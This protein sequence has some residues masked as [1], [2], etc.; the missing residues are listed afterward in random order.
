[1]NA[2]LS[3]SSG[4]PISWCLRFSQVNSGL[5][6]LQGPKSMQESFWKHWSRTAEN[7]SIHT[8][9]V[10][11][12]FFF[13]FFFCLNPFFRAPLK[14]KSLSD[15]CFGREKEW[16][17]CCLAVRCYCC[18]F[19]HEPVSDVVVEAIAGLRRS[20][21]SLKGTGRGETNQ[22]RSGTEYSIKAD[23]SKEIA[24]EI[25]TAD[26]LASPRWQLNHSCAETVQHSAFVQ[27]WRERA[28]ACWEFVI[29]HPAAAGVW[30]LL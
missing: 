16:H 1:M 28:V 15:G 3:E 2:A 8:C 23:L 29:C 13:F 18:C 10:Y 7:K 25:P 9:R 24:A 4:W 30:S 27:I 22:E 14:K 26:K 6:G 11:Y 17:F 12:L 19:G 5:G 21:F 20:L